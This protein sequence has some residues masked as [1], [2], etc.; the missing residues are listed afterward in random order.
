MIVLALGTIMIQ[1]DQIRDAQKKYIIYNEQAIT[2]IPPEGKDPE[3]AECDRYQ[4]WVWK[5]KWVEVK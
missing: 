2:C 1:V 3:T 4:E 5:G